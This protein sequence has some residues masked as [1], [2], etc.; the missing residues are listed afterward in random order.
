MRTEASMGHA[1]RGPHENSIWLLLEGGT[2]IQVCAE[3][4]S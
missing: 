3:A 4:R 2:S 1:R